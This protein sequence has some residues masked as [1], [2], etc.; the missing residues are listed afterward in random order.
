M[1]ETK[2]KHIIEAALFAAAEPISVDRLQ[3][4]FEES[5]RP[6]VAEIKQHLA[7]LAEDYQERGVQLHEVGNGYRF[8]SQAEFAPWIQRL[9]EKKPPRY[10]RAF[11]E[12]LSLII[13]RQPISRG[14]IEEVRGVVV[15]TDIMK[16]LLD[17]DWIKIVGYRDVPGKPALYG[18]TKKFLDYFNLKSL[19]DLPPL[20]DV[21]DLDKAEKQLTEQ[22]GLVAEESEI[23]ESAVEIESEILETSSAE[24]E[25]VV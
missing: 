11:L 15:S 14:E 23:I 1:S 2:Y 10:S 25:P 12:T 19:S 5:E 9:W 20:E 8:Q 6:T 13:Y 22:L 24:P 21:L 3:Q 16:K 17:H 18:T 7:A 4:L